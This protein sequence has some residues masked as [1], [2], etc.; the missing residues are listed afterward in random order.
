MATA[1]FVTTT[2]IAKFTSLNGNLD[3]DKFTDKM[4]VA[5]DIHIQSILGTD[6]FN[7][8]NNDIVASTLIAP[9][10]T[11]LTSYIKPMVIHYTM[12]EYLPFAS[13]TIGNKGVYKHGS[14]NGET[15][16]KEEMDSLI[17]KERSLAQH[18][19]Q[20]FVDYICFNSASFPEYNSNSNGDMFP[21]R[22]VNLSGWFL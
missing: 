13:Y 22:D 15:I 7:K 14:E 18:Y 16:S 12:V 2:D 20:R 10:T 19:T 21:D 3:P 11:L 1:L 8:I 6:L 9:Y 5:Q 17:E 4:K